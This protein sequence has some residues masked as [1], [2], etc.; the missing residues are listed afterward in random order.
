MSDDIAAQGLTRST[1]EDSASLGDA[2]GLGSLG[3]ITGAEVTAASLVRWW[4][5]L[6]AR[7]FDGRLPVARCEVASC[8]S[9]RAFSESHAEGDVWVVTVAP[10][11]ARAGELYAVAQL[12]HE[13]VHAWCV[14]VLGDAE[15]AYSHHGPK[16]IEC[17][18]SV[19]R[20]LGLAVRTRRQAG[21]GYVTPGVWPG[22]WEARVDVAPT[23]TD[24]EAEKLALEAG[25]LRARLVELEAKLEAERAQHARDQARLTDVQRGLAALRERYASK[26]STLRARGA[27]S[28]GVTAVTRALLALAD[29]AHA[30]VRS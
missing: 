20:A 15:E 4:S 22:L 8:R 21:D 28:G 12:L 19:A 10:H 24:V 1:T 2:S 23:R 17:A 3:G 9:P 11:V 5:V 27:T 16:F 7:C 13:G 18:N 29:E 6:S 25:I 26:L 14:T 30:L